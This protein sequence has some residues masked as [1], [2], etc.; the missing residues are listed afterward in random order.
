M[1]SR[2]VV[3]QVAVLDIHA[4]DG[5]A[6]V[7]IEVSGRGMGTASLTSDH[8]AVRQRL[9]EEALRRQALHD[10]TSFWWSG[11]R[12]RDQRIL[13]AQVA[14]A[15]LRDWDWHHIVEPML[16]AVGP[17]KTVFLSSGAPTLPAFSVR[18]ALRQGVRC[19]ELAPE[20]FFRLVALNLWMG[21]GS[22]S[23]LNLAL[24]GVLPAFRPETT[25]LLIGPEP[26][27][28]SQA[29]DALL[30]DLP[31]TSPSTALTDVLRPDEFEAIDAIVTRVRW[32]E[33]LQRTASSLASQAGVRY[34]A[35][36]ESGD[37]LALLDRPGTIRTLGLAVHQ[38]AQGLHF[39]DGVLPLD[40][41]RTRLADMRRRGVP[42]DAVDLAV[43]GAEAPGNLADCFQ[44]C[45]T[46]I[47]LTYGPFA[48]F[49][50]VVLGWINLLSLAQR[51][52]DLSLPELIDRSWHI[53]YASPMP[54]R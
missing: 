34:V 54:D 38:D 7:L 49:A 51:G 5:R 14:M 28:W 45:G 52:D 10:E 43:C 12:V 40:A 24:R 39:A 17:S 53:A 30:V 3:E 13:E 11:E 37:L 41:V 29:L 22:E 16:P 20:Q 26:K 21:A 44:S 9:A 32:T 31:D 50:R 8:L 25:A 36:A 27:G 33:V 46:P 23:L 35:E 18:G 42:L 47:V 19:G 48:H 1:S 6:E 2:T 15:T 4:D